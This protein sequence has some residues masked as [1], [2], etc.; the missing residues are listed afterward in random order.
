MGVDTMNVCRL[1]NFSGAV[2]AIGL[3]F[4]TKSS[5]LKIV[6]EPVFRAGLLEPDLQANSES[7]LDLHHLLVHSTRWPVLDRVS[8][9]EEERALSVC[10][11][12]GALGCQCS[13]E[14]CQAVVGIVSL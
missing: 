4:R 14:D 5:E 8:T 9:L 2:S 12:G 1:A 6:T 13:V 7:L 11:C 3:C 10:D